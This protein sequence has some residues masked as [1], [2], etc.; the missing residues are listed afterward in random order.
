MGRLESP[1]SINTYNQC[2]RKYYYSY[3][4]KLPRTD[5]IATIRG[6]AVHDALENFFKINIKFDINL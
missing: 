5:T 1:N 2:K 6:K 4:L 3:K